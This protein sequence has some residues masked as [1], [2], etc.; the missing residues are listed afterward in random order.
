MVGG[1]HRGLRGGQRHSV[2]VVARQWP[3]LHQAVGAA[4]DERGVVGG[5]GHVPDGALVLAHAGKCV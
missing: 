2:G 1:Q 5:E 4:R 3:H